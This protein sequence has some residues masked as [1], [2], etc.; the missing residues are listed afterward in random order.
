M[1]STA[2][3]RLGEARASLATAEIAVAAERATALDQQLS[4]AVAEV[5]SL[6]A[7]IVEQGK[8]LFTAKQDAEALWVQR[9]LVQNALRNLDDALPEFPLVNELE[10]YQQKRSVLV[11]EFESLSRQL[12]DASVPVA[13]GN[14]AIQKLT[15]AKHRAELAVSDLKIAVREAKT[16]TRQRM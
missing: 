16:G 12:T 3:Q 5:R 7:E 9:A 8:R 4:E 15:W 2:Q 11:E 13:Q 1:S 14:D 6:D 10:E